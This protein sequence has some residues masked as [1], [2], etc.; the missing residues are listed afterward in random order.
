MM[1]IAMITLFW[2]THQ[3]WRWTVV[4][5]RTTLMTRDVRSRMISHMLIPMTKCRQPHCLIP[6]CCG[7]PP[8]TSSQLAKPQNTALPPCPQNSL[9][10]HKL[11]FL[12]AHPHSPHGHIHHQPHQPL[13][14]LTRRRPRSNCLLK[15]MTCI[16][17]FPRKMPCS[18]LLKPTA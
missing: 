8:Q 4:M 11:H 7:Q 18:K 5:T 9:A 2:D 17:N 10:L 3:M 16:T 1:R 15:T 13:K 12:I 6:T 14:S